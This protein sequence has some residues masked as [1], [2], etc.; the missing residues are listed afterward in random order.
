MGSLKNET[1]CTF[2][3]NF[4]VIGFI[5]QVT[6]LH[7]PLRTTHP[8]VYLSHLSL[9]SFPHADQNLL[10]SSLLFSSE[11]LFVLKTF[12][13]SASEDT[14][15]SLYHT[16][17]PFISKPLYSYLSEGSRNGSMLLFFM[18]LFLD[19]FSLLMDCKIED[20]CVI[21]VFT[22]VDL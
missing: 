1:F 20:F 18:V 13:V 10:I 2:S 5:S 14:R 16:W 4:F 8:F 6:W 7:V 9:Y 11:A 17:V 15:D 21:R 3:P 19:M 12:V 22:G